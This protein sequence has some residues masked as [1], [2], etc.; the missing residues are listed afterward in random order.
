MI[1]TYTP[2][3]YER[4]RQIHALWLARSGGH[5]YVD[6]SD[7]RPQIPIGY[8]GDVRGQNRMLEWMLQDIEWHRRQYGSHDV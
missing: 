6:V 2:E 8:V 7:P 1:K 4:V 5:P 3:Y